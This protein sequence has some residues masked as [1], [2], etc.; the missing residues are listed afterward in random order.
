LNQMVFPAGILQQPFFSVAR[1]QAVNIGAIG[2]VMG[3]E[4]THGFDDQ[5]RKLDGDGNLIDS[6][7]PPVAVEFDKRAVCV[8]DQFDAYVAVEDARVNGK[9]TLSENLAD[10]GGLK[11]GLSAL[12]AAGPPS[13]EA[14]RQFF[15]G[16]AQVWC[17][18]RRPET[19]KMLGQVDPHAPPRWRVDG[20]ISNMPEFASAFSCQAGDAMVRPPENRCT[21]W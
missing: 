21:V 3:H 13:P 10:L 4:L 14:D 12:R 6:W 9:L 18:E 7:T 8:A 11:L 2:V 20:P 5:G 17:G 15:I 19:T 1:P 16:Y